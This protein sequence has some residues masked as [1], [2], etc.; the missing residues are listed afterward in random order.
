K[1]GLEKSSEIIPYIAYDN[2]RLYRIDSGEDPVVP[3]VEPEDPTEPTGP[4][5]LYNL[6][7]KA[8]DF[9]PICMPYDVKTAY[10]GQVYTIGSIQNGVATIIPVNEVAA[11]VSCVVKSSG[12]STIKKGDVTLNYS[13]GTTSI[14]LWDN[15]MMQGD[16]NTCTW[17]A[18]DINNNSIDVA[19]LEFV[20]ADL[21][22]L[23][24]TATIE[25]NAAARFWAQ[26]PTYLAETPT[27]IKNY[28]QIYSYIKGTDKSGKFMYRNDKPNP[29]LVPVFPSSS[30]QTVSFWRKADKSDKKTVT[31]SRNTN[32][33]EIYDDIYPG[34][35]Y[36]YES[37]YGNA[38]GKFTV[39]GSLRMMYI[40]INVVNIRDLGGKKGKDGKYVRYGKLY[41]SAQL[42]GC[43]WNQ[44]YMTTD[45][46]RKKLVALGVDAEIDL[47]NTD[48]G[49]DYAWLPNAKEGENFYYAKNGSV[50]ANGPGR[51]YDSTTKKLLKGEFEFLVKNLKR[52]NNTV[53]V[54]YHCR[55]GADRTGLFTFL[56]L[57]LLGVSEDDILR[58]YESTSFSEAGVRTKDVGDSDAA[59]STY[60]K[61]VPTFRKTASTFIGAFEN[62][63][64]NVL[65]VSQTNIDDFRNIML[66]D[67]PLPA[68]I[69]A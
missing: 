67:T 2:F 48:G 27:C 19:N 34:L 60:K 44:D 30:S 53:A 6:N 45:E 31:V 5:E 46:E 69:E 36:N 22:N 33:A 16:Y 49:I 51:L 7:A 37:S 54:Q 25:N 35:T 61:E 68:D 62:Y 41:R 28:N 64:L 23:E 18:T 29:I 52:N 63:F 55:I 15:T 65:G 21:K 50:T 9:V 59:A 47:R 3:P 12:T 14:S 39:D 17:T 58:D 1:N 4:I 57:G 32:V 13:A 24:F 11:G 66:G 38:A 43:T 20:E 8:G 40:G 26:N 42:N 10:F 56:I